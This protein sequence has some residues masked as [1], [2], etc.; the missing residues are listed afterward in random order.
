MDPVPEARAT[1]AKAL[2]TLVGAHSLRDRF[3]SRTGS[4]ITSHLS[5]YSLHTNC[6]SSLSLSYFRLR[7]PHPTDVINSALYDHLTFVVVLTSFQLDFVL[8]RLLRTPCLFHFDPFSFTC[9]GGRVT[10]FVCLLCHVLFDD[11]SFFSRPIFSL[12]WIRLPGGGSL[13]FTLCVSRLPSI[14][15][16]ARHF[17]LFTPASFQFLFYPFAVF[18][19]RALYIIHTLALYDPLCIFC[20]QLTHWHLFSYHEIVGEGNSPVAASHGESEGSYDFD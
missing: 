15:L 11:Y 18:C 17:C 5:N 6:L 16:R 12:F 9:F 4:T 20:C 13:I 3:E 8:F 7:I 19:T 2:G 14:T 10:I 1:A